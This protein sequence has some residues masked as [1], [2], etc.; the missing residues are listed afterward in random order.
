MSLTKIQNTVLKN[1]YRRNL[2]INGAMQIWQRGTALTG[3][4]GSTS[5]FLPDRFSLETGSMTGTMGY[6]QIGNPPSGTP[7]I[8]SPLQ[9]YCSAIGTASYVSIL[10]SIEGYDFNY[11]KGKSCVLSFWAWTNNPGTYYIAF[12][13]TSNNYSYVVPY[14]MPATTWTYVV[15]PVTFPSSGVTFG[16]ANNRGVNICWNLQQQATTTSTFNSWISGNYIN[17]PNQANI[18]ESF[19]NAFYMMGVQLEVGNSP[20]PFELRTLNKE[21]NLCKRYYEKSYNMFTA[22][23]TITA[24]GSA[25]EYITVGGT[26]TIG[27]GGSSVRFAVEKC[28]TPTVTIYSTGT[29][30][31]GKVY[32]F[33]NSTDYN[34]GTPVVATTGFYWNGTVNVATTMSMACNWTASCE[35]L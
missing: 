11:I 17:G 18:L 24:S 31:A 6:R 34:A 33:T 23:G 3:I 9:A 7:F 20:S 29:G 15:I 19:N 22:P 28:Y 10:Y 8:H 27:S 16:S 12:R 1:P 13:G 30:T 21:G 35:I 4:T 5:N 26:S 32:S 2:I 25:L 14:T